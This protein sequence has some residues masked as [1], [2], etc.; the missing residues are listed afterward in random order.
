MY[1]QGFFTHEMESGALSNIRAII[2][3]DSNKVLLSFVSKVSGGSTE[4]KKAA[5]KRA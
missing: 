2:T 5:D 3:G 4:R 1:R